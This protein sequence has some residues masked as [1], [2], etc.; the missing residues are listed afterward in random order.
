MNRFDELLG[1]PVDTRSI[2]VV[3][4]LVGL[5]AFV[6]LRPIATEGLAGRTFHDRFHE[7][8]LDPLFDV[9]PMPGPAL[10]TALMSVG[11]LAAVAMSLGAVTKVATV[12]TTGAVGYHLLVSTTHLHNNRAYLFA[13]LLGLSLAPAGRSYSVDRWWRTHRGLETLPE[14]MP[15]WPLWLLRFESSLVYGAS[16]FSKLIDADWFGGTVTW[17]RVVTHEA[18]LRSSALPE[19]AQELLLDRSFHTVAA[20]VVVVTE[21]FIAIGLWWRRSRPWALA[22][23][24][25][26]HVAIELSASVQTFSFLAVAVLFVWADPDL[27]HV[28]RVEVRRFRIPGFR[29]VT[30]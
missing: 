24:V 21:L 15:G 11:T 27:R 22:T 2:G 13:V 28:G 7:P 5:V 6:H 12:V 14:L 20:K 3:R 1:R 9:V 26:F 17:G 19:V 10:F 25:A 18:M 29:K 16:G 4:I 8:F 23:A 30:A